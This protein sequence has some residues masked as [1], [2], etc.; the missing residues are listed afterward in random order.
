MVHLLAALEADLRLKAADAQPVRLIPFLSAK[1]LRD[2][3]LEVLAPG[4]D[5]LQARPVRDGDADPI[6]ARGALSTPRK[7]GCIEASSTMRPAISS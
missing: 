4:T 2:A 7:P 3:M 1:F 6:T 5:R